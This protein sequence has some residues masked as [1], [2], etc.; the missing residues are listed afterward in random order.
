MRGPW[1][2][3]ANLD[4]QLLGPCVCSR[5]SCLDREGC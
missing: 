4:Q 5:D 2:G 3:L 1:K